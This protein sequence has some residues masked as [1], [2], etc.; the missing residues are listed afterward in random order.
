VKVE[1]FALWADVDGDN[2]RSGEAGW[3][4]TVSNL[5]MRLVQRETNQEVNEVCG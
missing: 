2:Y 4:Y 3:L 5:D 1:A